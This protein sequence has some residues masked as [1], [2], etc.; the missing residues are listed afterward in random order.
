[1]IIA[2]DHDMTTRNIIRQASLPPAATIPWWGNR[3][4]RYQFT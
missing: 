1:V 4:L 2:N 3:T